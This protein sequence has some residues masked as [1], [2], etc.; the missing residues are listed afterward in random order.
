[1]LEVYN[2]TWNN[3]H[4]AQTR[5]NT[6]CNLKK[7]LEAY[8][9]DMSCTD[10]AFIQLTGHGQDA[11]AREAFFQKLHG[12]PDAVNKVKTMK[13][14]CNVLGCEDVATSLNRRWFD[15]HPPAIK[16]INQKRRIV[17][18]KLADSLKVDMNQKRPASLLLDAM[19]QK[20][21]TELTPETGQ[22]VA[23]WFDQMMGVTLPCLRAQTMTLKWARRRVPLE[24]FQ[25]T[26]ENLVVVKKGE[27]VQLFFGGMKMMTTERYKKLWRKRILIDA[28]GVTTHDD[29]TRVPCHMSRDDWEMFFGMICTYLGSLIESQG[30]FKSGNKVFPVTD[31]GAMTDAFWNVRFGSHLQRIIFR[32]GVTR[33]DAFFLRYVMQHSPDADRTAYVK[34]EFQ[35]GPWN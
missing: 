5:R 29:G 4:G 13:T 27:V 22:E 3:T 23:F 12:L 15:E 1:M 17:L 34:K 8:G 7:T 31:L 9:L 20:I 10:V 2:K 28:N 16:P 14:L 21:F 24:R 19:Q 18:D 6:K 26:D 35:E 33:S 11:A 25:E 32:N 30:G